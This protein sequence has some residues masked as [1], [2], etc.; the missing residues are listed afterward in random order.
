[1]GSPWMGVGVVCTPLYLASVRFESH[2]PELVEPPADRSESVRI[3]AI[4]PPRALGAIGHEARIL[5]HLKVLRDGGTSHRQSACDLADGRFT[6]V[7][8]LED[9]TA[10]GIREGGERYK[11]VSHG[12]L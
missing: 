12:L 1:M 6:G 7:Q 5:Q 2:V 4:H 10:G 3:D 9:P 8:P 11:Y